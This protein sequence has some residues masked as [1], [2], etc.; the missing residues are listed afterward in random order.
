MLLEVKTH[1]AEGQGD[2]VGTNCVSLAFSGSLGIG[3]SG[4]CDTMH[5]GSFVNKLI[6]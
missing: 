5:F 6:G 2:Y 4:S 3:S 1:G